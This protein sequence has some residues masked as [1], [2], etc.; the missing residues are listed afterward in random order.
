MIKSNLASKLG[1]SY[2]ENNCPR[3]QNIKAGNN[4]T[5]IQFTI[6]DGKIMKKL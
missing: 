5:R 3:R 6:R 1:F 2:Q 4:C